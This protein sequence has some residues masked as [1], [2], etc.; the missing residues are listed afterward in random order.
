MVDSV[1]CRLPSIA[2]AWPRPAPARPSRAGGSAPPGAPAPPARRTTGRPPRRP[3]ARPAWGRPRTP[4]PTTTA[5]GSRPPAPGR[6]GRHRGRRLQA[7]RWCSSPAARPPGDGAVRHLYPAGRRAR[8]R[9]ALRRA[10]DHRHAGGPGLGAAPRPRTRRAAGAQHERAHA[11][12]RPRPRAS[13]KPAASVFSA[14]IAPP[15]TASA[16]S[17]RRWPRP[18]RERCRPAPARPPCAARSRSAPRKPD[19]GSARDRLGE[20]LRRH[21]QLARSASPGPAR[22]GPRSCMAGERL[23]ATGKPATPSVSGPSAAWSA[24]CPRARARRGCSGP[25]RAGTRRRSRRSRARRRCRA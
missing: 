6:P 13:R 25:R 18:P 16:C 3:T 8:A 23:W 22:P 17:R 24:T 14:A 19:A 1:P 11:A 20:Q 5:G 15:S 9:G 10:V 12:R 2:A 4:G 21:R 7:R